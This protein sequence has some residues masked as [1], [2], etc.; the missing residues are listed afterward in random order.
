MASLP[1]KLEL[2]YDVL[3]P[4]SWLGFEILCRY[5][6]I[7]NI[8][9]QLHPTFIGGIMKDSGN[10]R[11]V[12]VPRKK[13][14]LKDELQYL[15]EFYQVPLVI[16]RDLRGVVIDKGSLD[17]MRFLSSVEIK[18]PEMLEKVSRELWMRIWSRDEDITEP[19]SIQIAAEKA[20]FS[21]EQAKG[22]LERCSTEEVKE[23]LRE[24]TDTACKYGAF[25][26]PTVLFHMDDKSHILFGSDRLELLAHLLGAQAGAMFPGQ[27][28]GRLVKPLG[29]LCCSAILLGFVLLGQHS[30]I[31]PVA[32]LCLALGGLL[33]FIC[34]LSCFKEWGLQAIR[35][36]TSGVLSSGQDNAAFEVPNYEEAVVSTQG[37]NSDLGEPPPYNTVIPSP[38]QEGESNHL[39]GLTGARTERRGRSEGT[40]TQTEGSLGTPI[41]LRLRGHLMLSETPPSQSLPRLEPLTPPP[42]YEL[43]PSN[44]DINDDSV[45]YE[46]GWPPP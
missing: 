6:N 36:D 20:G 43:S 42:A 8:D 34:L 28:W 30:N 1:R 14:Y 21:E 31:K 44:H 5:R 32:Y 33:L 9:C 37:P 39:A 17:A 41:N 13:K 35:T 4:Y 45:F 25:G 15:A 10:L 26:L 2:F 7:W 46:E 11:P 29:L 27:V 22:L 16:P 24:T 19:Q 18:N 23:K 12:F 3:S 40:M 38:L